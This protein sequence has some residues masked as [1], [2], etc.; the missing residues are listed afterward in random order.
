MIFN[1][2]SSGVFLPLSWMIEIADG[3]VHTRNAICSIFLNFI[4]FS[5]YKLYGC[6]IIII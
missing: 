4:F 5:K 1:I 2:L 6:I 3:F